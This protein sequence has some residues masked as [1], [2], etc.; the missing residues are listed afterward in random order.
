MLDEMQNNTMW[1]C[2][3][4]GTSMLASHAGNFCARRYAAANHKDSSRISFS[5][6]RGCIRGAAKYKLARRY[7]QNAP[8]NK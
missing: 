1:T 6:C 3:K 2:T 8:V 5:H 7:I 4:Y